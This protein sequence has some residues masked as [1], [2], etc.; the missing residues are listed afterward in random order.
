MGC[1]ERSAHV[2][3]LEVQGRKHFWALGADRKEW[4]CGGNGRLRGSLEGKEKAGSALTF[5]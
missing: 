5:E 3:P 1:L 2:W 4:G